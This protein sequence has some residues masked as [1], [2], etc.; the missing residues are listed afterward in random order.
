MLKARKLFNMLSKADFDD[1][2]PSRRTSTFAV[3]KYGYSRQ[4]L[5]E[6]L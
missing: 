3:A 5:A 1:I 2:G 4:T 6:I